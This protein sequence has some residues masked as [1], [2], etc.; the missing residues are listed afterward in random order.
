MVAPPVVAKVV[1]P[2]LPPPVAPRPAPPV[3][4]TP[5]TEVSAPITPAP[6]SE[7]PPAPEP[8]IESAVSLPEEPLPAPAPVQ[9]KRPDANMIDLSLAAIVAKVPREMLPGLPPRIG[10]GD[11]ISL[12]FPIIE[13]QLGTGSVSI[14]ATLFWDA[15]PPMLRHHFILREDLV[16]PVPLE[17]IFQ[18]LPVGGGGEKPR[19][20]PIAPPSML[21]PGKETPVVLAPAP[22]ADETPTLDFDRPLPAPEN[23][24]PRESPVVSN[25]ARM[26]P[27]APVEADVPPPEPPATSTAAPTAEDILLAPLPPTEPE[28]AA[29]SA[30]DQPGF[31]HLQPFRVFHLPTPEVEPAAALAEPAP[32]IVDATPVVEPEVEENV[33][34]EPE[35]EAAEKQVEL[36]SV[37]S[38]PEPA[39]EPVPPVPPF[40]VAPAMRP[41]EEPVVAFTHDQPPPLKIE[42]PAAAVAV[43]RA[44]VPAPMETPPAAM[45]T[46]SVQPPPMFRPMVLPPPVTGVPAAPPV[47]LAPTLSGPGSIHG[48][49]SLAPAV[50]GKTP[51][52]DPPASTP[53]PPPQPVPVVAAPIPPAPPAAAPAPVAP[54]PLAASP[55]RVD[56]GI[57]APAPSSPPP[58]AFVPPPLPAVP[59]SVPAAPATEP[60]PFHLHLPPLPSA[61][62]PTPP[63]PEH[64]P[65]ALPMSRFD[66]HSLQ[67]LFM[68]EEMI[69][70]PKVARLAAALPG[71]QACVIAARGETFSSGLLPEGFQLGALRGLSPQVDAAADRLPIGQL[72]NFTLYGEQYSVSFFERTAVCLCAIHRARSFVPGVREKLVAVVDELARG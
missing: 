20:D 3:V 54:P 52:F 27:P 41:V 65:P 55:L 61:P 60:E 33:D 17:E 13:R 24:P 5:P 72:K 31:V 37:P 26:E 42:E 16:V 49:I 66:Q 18:N 62:A 4:A 39:P 69:D 35:S 11:R 56:R 64:L 10:D 38:S 46:V 28:P 44:S 25:E 34:R 71:I 67:S 68:T 70:L 32:P 6:A 19:F 14:P 1:E 15:L 57:I 51:A 40:P 58:A 12:P 48:M 8:P 7:V 43:L 23:E 53:L 45:A 47:H 63:H 50:E 9:E 22:I 29:A 21:S 59:A 30:H 36:P 2:V